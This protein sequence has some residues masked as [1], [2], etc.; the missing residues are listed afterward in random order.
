MSR[1]YTPPYV[2]WLSFI[3]IK[4]ILSVTLKKKMRIEEYKR[5]SKTL[6][7]L[8]EEKTCHILW[9]ENSLKWVLA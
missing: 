6:L 5:N 3:Q 1:F 7:Y 4:L 2:N 9:T 8:K